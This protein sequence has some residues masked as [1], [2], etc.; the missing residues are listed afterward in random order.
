MPRAA[1]R[2]HSNHVHYK[3]LS[4]LDFILDHV[5][6]IVGAVA[7]LGILAAYRQV[8]WL[9]GVIIVPD[10]SVGVVTKKFVLLARIEVCRMDGFLHST[11]RQATRLIRSRRVCIW[12]CG[13]G[14]TLSNWSSSLRFRW[15]A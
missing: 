8:L 9:V 3:G 4:I 13:P 15:V 14:N 5:W 11:E 2:L 1:T 10:D 6:Q 7:I 12:P